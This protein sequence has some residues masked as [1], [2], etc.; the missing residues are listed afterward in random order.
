[1]IVKELKRKIWL[2]YLLCALWFVLFTFGLKK[3]YDISVSIDMKVD[4]EYR[5]QNF[6]DSADMY[7]FFRNCTDAY[8]MSKQ[9][10][11]D[12]FVIQQRC[13]IVRSFG[14]ASP[15]GYA[16]VRLFAWM[17]AIM[18][19]SVLGMP[20]ILAVLYRHRILNGGHLGER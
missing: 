19:V 6:T 11:G 13:R 14:D 5:A 9:D 20:A 3:T 7:E 17:L 16:M 4:V 8:S 1:M 2:A 10:F 12:Y 18:V 15:L